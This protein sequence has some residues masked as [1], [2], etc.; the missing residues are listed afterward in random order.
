MNCH[1]VFSDDRNMVDV[2]DDETV[3]LCIG[4]IHGETYTWT[5]LEPEEAI[6]LGN[7]LVAAGAEAAA[8]CCGE[9]CLEAATEFEDE[10]PSLFVVDDMPPE[11]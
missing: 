8:Q 7:A 4:S 6:A 9:G 2:N 5:T 10:S 11:L 3:S 1:A